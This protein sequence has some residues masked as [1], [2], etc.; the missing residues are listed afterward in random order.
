ME[1]LEDI[2][3]CLEMLRIKR[4]KTIRNCLNLELK[5][6]Q[7]KVLIQKLT[8][9]AELKENCLLKENNDLILNKNSYLYNDLP[10][11]KELKL[12]V[13][14]RKCLEKAVKKLKCE[15]SKLDSI[16]SE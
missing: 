16:I 4:K 12:A 5:N 3:F 9:L 1:R 15:I 6:E 2:D 7:L 8:N 11:L 14:K 10:L 13:K